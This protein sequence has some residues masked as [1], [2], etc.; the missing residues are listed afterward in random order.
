MVPARPTPS[1]P[2]RLRE[3]YRLQELLRSSDTTQIWLA[4]DEKLSRMVAVYLS[5]SHGTDATGLLRAARAA[6]TVPDTRFLQVLD[7][8]DDGS[9]AYVVTEW[10]ADATTLS[11]LLSAG[12]LPPDDAVRLV[13]DVSDALATA[14]DLGQFHI[15]LDPLTVLV[16]PSRQ[17]KIQGLRVEAALA[18]LDD[19]DRATSEAADV[20]ALGA[21]LYAALT[22]TWPFGN[23]C[24]LPPA[25]LDGGIPRPPD[26]VTSRI[27]ADVADLCLQLLAPGQLTGP[28]VSSCRVA[29]EQ[30]SQLGHSARLAHVTEH[31]PAA[32]PA[33]PTQHRTTTT[34]LRSTAAARHTAQQPIV[35]SDYRN[36][37]GR[38]SLLLPGVLALLL[39]GT[40]ALLGGRALGILGSDDDRD[41]RSVSSQ[42]P[43]DGSPGEELPL[44]AASLWD[45]SEGTEHADD[46]DNTL[47]GA[48]GG[49]QTSCYVNGPD[50]QTKPGTGIIYDLGSVQTVRSSTVTIGAPG[51]VLEMWASPESMTTL[52]AV[53]P[54]SAPPGFLALATVEADSTIVDLVA[55]EPVRTRFVLVW[56][57]ALPERPVDSAHPHPYYDSIVQVR[58][59][60]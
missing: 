8:I 29:H 52:P 23:G 35:P 3:R 34:M 44:V 53:V 11:A 37:R 31:A 28:P 60:R 50:I 5:A 7:A 42:A 59:F 41:S 30:L 54:R 47:T 26:E 10:V 22:A 25:P 12:P 20:Q 13:T 24:G 51:A 15:R 36:R 55:E 33:P 46:V 18:G 58:V 48:D 4:V 38:S 17:V 2:G 39:I 43:T 21:L 56:F 9:N 32:P 14:H 57:T 45:A 27:P 40:L 16:T 6:A 1:L 19:T 49:W